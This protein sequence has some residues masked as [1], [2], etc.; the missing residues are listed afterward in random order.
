MI[1]R[2]LVG[3]GAIV[4]L[5][6]YLHSAFG[7]SYT[8]NV[9]KPPAEVR[10]ALRDLDIRNAPGEPASDPSRSGGIEPVF[11]LSETGNDM[12][13]TITSGNQVAVKLIAHLEPTDGGQHTK[14]TAEVERGDAP[15]DHV[16][17]AFRSTSLTRSLF[18]LVLDQ[19]L[20]QM[21]VTQARDSE[22][23]QKIMD[24]FQASGPQ[25]GEDQRGFGGVAKTALRLNALEGKLKAAGCPTGFQGKF[26]PVSNEMGEGGSPPP[27][28]AEDHRDGVSFEPGK[29]MID[30]SK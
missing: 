13:W 30:P 12:V 16:A 17:P 22:S 14:V 5:G 2:S 20:D 19:E 27:T 11:Q 25:W 21:N 4:G 10:E 1:L 18:G 3:G 26:E 15:D 6:L 23:C 28:A 7:P 24:D 8:R 9:G 29:P